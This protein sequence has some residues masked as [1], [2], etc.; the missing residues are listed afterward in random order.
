MILYFGYF[1]LSCIQSE[2][3]IK[4]APPVTKIVIYTNVNY[5]SKTTIFKTQNIDF[6]VKSMQI[7]QY[8]P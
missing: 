5:T 3:P 8:L 6:V 2:E 1:S 7:Y 4:P